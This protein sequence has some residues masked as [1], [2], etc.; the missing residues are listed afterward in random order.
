MKNKIFILIVLALVI[1]S[2]ALLAFAAD[3]SWGIPTQEEIQTGILNQTVSTP[4][5]NATD[6]ADAIDTVDVK[7]LERI[8]AMPKVPEITKKRVEKPNVIAGKTILATTQIPWI[9][10]SNGNIY[11]WTESNWK[12]MPGSA[13]DIGA[14]PDG[15]VWIIG[16][17][18]VPGGFGIYKWNGSNWDPQPGGAVQIT[19]GTNERTPDS[20]KK[21]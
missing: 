13:A 1:H 2:L 11:Q 10:N 5:V 3:S 8:N 16:T 4:K 19:V 7:Q 9:V 18:P 17:N 15:A 12:R 6:K 21:W 20:F 14:G